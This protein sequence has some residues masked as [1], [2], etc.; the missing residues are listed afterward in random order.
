[1]TYDLRSQNQSKSLLDNKDNDLMTYSN[2]IISLD[3]SRRV[4]SLG[5]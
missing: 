5:N 4:H 2:K 3:Q 1:M